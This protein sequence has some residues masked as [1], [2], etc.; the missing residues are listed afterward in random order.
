MSSSAILRLLRPHATP[1]NGADRDDAL[2]ARFRHSRDE[3][4][5]G[6]IVQRYGRLVWSVC[7]QMLQHKTDAED[8]YQA[9]FLALIRSSHTIRG[10]LAPW[11]HRVAYRVS[12]KL[13]QRLIKQSQRDKLQAR[14]EATVPVPDSAWDSMLATVHKEI[15]QLPEK[16]RVPLVLCCMEGQGVTEAAQSVGLKLG[17]FSS[18]LTQAKQLLLYRLTRRGLSITAAGLSII[19]I[20][21][22]SAISPAHYQLALQLLQRGAVSPLITSLCHGVVVMYTRMQLAAAV[23]VLL[24]AAGAA[25]NA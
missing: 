1:I 7:R 21:Q 23:T 13:R 8:A 18:R 14:R 24:G 22:A 9:T 20:S 10:P 19:T 5:F 6:I 3:Q 11:L 12:I 4:A 16:L 25:K 2:L 17:T 15:A